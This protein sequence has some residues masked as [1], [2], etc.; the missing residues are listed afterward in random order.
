M[1]EGAR[2]M[3]FW[4]KLGI[5]L[6]VG[7]IGV[8]M[9]LGFAVYLWRELPRTLANMGFGVGILMCLTGLGCF[10]FI[11]EIEQPEVIIKLVSQKEPALELHNV[12]N[13]TASNIKW[14]VVAFDIDN[15]DQNKQ[16]LPIP[17]DTFDFLVAG[18]TNLPVNLFS[19]PT[20]AP[21]VKQGHRIVGSASVHCPTCK[22]GHTITFFFTLGSGGWYSE[23]KEIKTGYLILPA[24]MDTIAKAADEML[25][26]TPESARTPI[27]DPKREPATFR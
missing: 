17:A 15:L 9:A 11:P 6:A 23:Q 21:L 25:R 4:S 19:R 14:M 27:A 3:D 20:V 10:I 12:S 2:H 18:A 5:A 26:E 8:S 16:P 13:V 7:G 22:R 24:S 1:P